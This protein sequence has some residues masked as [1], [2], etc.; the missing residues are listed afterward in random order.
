MVL[1]EM[2]MGRGKSHMGWQYV[3]E[4]SRGAGN[5]KDPDGRCLRDKSY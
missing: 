4:C 5:A 3:S 1:E 2:K